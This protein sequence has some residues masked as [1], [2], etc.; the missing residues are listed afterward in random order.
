MKK[1]I[2]FL[3]FLSLFYRQSI[4]QDRFFVIHAK[5]SIHGKPRF[6]SSFGVNMKLNGYLDLFG[7]LQDNE[8]FNVGLINVFGTDDQASLHIDMYQTQLKF[9]TSLITLS[10]QQINAVVESDFWGGNGTVRLRKAFVETD[11]WQIGQNWHNFGDEMIWPNIMEWEGPPS[12]VWQRVPHIKYKN[13]FNDKRYIYE[14]SLEAPLNDYT[15]YKDLEPFVQE[16]DQFT[17]DLTAA[18]RY[19]E[20]WGHL[21]LASVLRHIRYALQGEEDSFMGYGFSFSGLYRPADSKD[22]L[23]FQ[24]IGGKGI[25]AFMTSIAGQGYDGYPN[26]DGSFS[27]TPVF[28]GW[29][30]YEYFITPRLHANAVIGYTNFNIKDASRYI[31]LSDQEVSDIYLNGQLKHEHYYGIFNMMYDP[32]ERMTI[33]LELDYGVKR[34]DGEGSIN[35]LFVDRSQ[36]RDAMRISFG[37][38]FYF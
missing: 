10:G 3:L 6:T 35:Q 19:L 17:P 30:S 27:A 28:G 8:T 36:S 9:E 4:A 32:Y 37:F 23:Q 5:D 20:P 14:I 31:L 16:T 7:G 26:I 2:L 11:H 12:G 22:N 13:T 34:L 18:V 33:G 24:V 21:R 15:P 1:I 38:M 29:S 25:T